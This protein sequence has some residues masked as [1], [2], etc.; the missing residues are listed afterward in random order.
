MQQNAAVKL[1]VGIIASMLA[2]F[3]FFTSMDALFFGLSFGVG[4][5]FGEYTVNGVQM[6]EEAATEAFTKISKIGT[7]VGIITLILAIGFAVLAAVMFMGYS[8][9]QKEKQLAMQQYQPYRNPYQNYYQ[10]QNPYQNQN[11]YQ[12]QN[13]YQ[14]QNN[15]Q[16]QNQN[17]YQNQNPYQNN[18]QDQNASQNQSGYQN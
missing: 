1:I 4:A 16:N 18:Y 3:N 14:N 9:L 6:P 12:N 7:A 11:Y 10:N 17:Y 5:E 13:P 2:V 8:K 15:Y